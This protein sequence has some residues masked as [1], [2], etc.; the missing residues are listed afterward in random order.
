[1]ASAGYLFSFADIYMRADGCCRTCSSG[2][3]RAKRNILIESAFPNFSTR[4]A[5]L[6]AA[7]LPGACLLACLEPNLHDE[8][9]LKL[10]SAH[11]AG[12]RI[13]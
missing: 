3:G 8:Q 13:P 11:M 2:K 5:A 7:C 6:P 4:Q 9:L 12:R 1:M 10:H